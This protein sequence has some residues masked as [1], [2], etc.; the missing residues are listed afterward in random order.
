MKYN[1]LL[2]NEQLNYLKQIVKGKSSQEITDCLNKKYNLNLTIKQ[3]REL[4]KTNHLTSEINTKF[5]KGQ[6]AYNHKPIGYEFVRDDGYIE[7]KVAEPNQWKLK[8]TYIYE[9]KYGNIPKGYRV[10]FLDQD[11]TNYDINNLKLVKIEDI[12]IAKNKKLLSNNKSIT[13]TGLLI[14]Q[15]INKTYKLKKDS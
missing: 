12:L 11:K 7:I 9:N 14:S 10:I 1:S 2:N 3:I 8:Q 4:K 5:K 15:L 13:K 6:E